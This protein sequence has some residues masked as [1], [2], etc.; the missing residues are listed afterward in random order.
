MGSLDVIQLN[1][2]DRWEGSVGYWQI[3]N[4]FPTFWLAVFSM[5]WYKCNCNLSNIFACAR[6][7]LTRHVI[8]YSPA[9]TGEI[10]DCYTSQLTMIQIGKIINKS[11][12]DTQGASSPAT[13]GHVSHPNLTAYCIFWLEST[14]QKT[15][16]NA[17]VPSSW[18]C[19]EF[20]HSKSSQQQKLLKQHVQVHLA[21]VNSAKFSEL[22]LA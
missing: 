12:N 19:Y 5:T 9:K 14:S 17:T 15:T 16:D 1:C 11:R 6:L 21:C 3:C 22:K 18:C 13:S 2:T 4:R 20:K 8:Q 7:V 10:R